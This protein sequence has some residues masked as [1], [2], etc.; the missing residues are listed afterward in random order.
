M[1]G[2]AIEG[3]YS[4]KC[5]AVVIGRDYYKQYIVA[6][7][8]NFNVCKDRSDP[9]GFEKC[10]DPA[11]KS[12]KIWL[13]CK[14]SDPTQD[15]SECKQ[16]C[17]DYRK[18]CELVTI[19]DTNFQVSVPTGFPVAREFVDHI[20]ASIVNFRLD[21]TI[22]RL[23]K[24]Y[25][26]EKY[27][28]VCTSNVE[29]DSLALDLFSLAGTYVISGGLMV[30]GLVMGVIE[31]VVN[32]KKQPSEESDSTSE[33][34]TEE[35]VPLGVTKKAFELEKVKHQELKEFGL[36]DSADD[37]NDNV[38]QQIQALNSKMSEV[39]HE[40]RELKVSLFQPCIFFIQHLAFMPW[41][42]SNC[43]ELTMIFEGKIAEVWL[44]RR[45][46]CPRI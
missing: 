23:F 26:D 27:H 11:K 22:D 14:C 7:K 37:E 5:G 31:I 33:R 3:I 20:S 17:P 24:Q 19:A 45:Q 44:S 43:Q 30:I 15:P 9:K 18:Y 4:G 35:D 40:L 8:V 12:T 42:V 6:E 28:P 16:D 38:R 46:P 13:D 21:G 1:I 41:F 34:E 36:V 2:P 10:Q 29:S 25:I 39:I 32:K